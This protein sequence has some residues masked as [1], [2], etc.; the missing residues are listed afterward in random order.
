MHVT[1]QALTL[2]EYA[3]FISMFT[4]PIVATVAAFAFYFMTRVNL[5]EKYGPSLIPVPIC[6]YG[7]YNGK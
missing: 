5:E 3:L 6:P 7:R 1:L 2:I 4:L